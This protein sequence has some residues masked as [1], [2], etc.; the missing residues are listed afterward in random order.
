MNTSLIT[1]E[2]EEYI[3]QERNT[4]WFVGLFVVTAA[5]S[6]LA[7]WLQW[8]TFLILVLVILAAILIRCF[9]KPS[10]IHYE[11]SNTSLREGKQKYPLSVFKAFGILK[12]GAHFSVV[13]IPK[14]RLGLAVKV[15]FPK[16][17]GEA[18]VDALGAKLPME[19]VKLDF[20][21]KL[22]NFLR[23]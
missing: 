23:I 22:V 1:W 3:E 10:A 14:K 19:E 9:R 20:L 12:E 17:N 13:L 21:D 8:W 16:Q 18:I 5:L 6:G 11:L 7:V 4:W 15:Y 2:G